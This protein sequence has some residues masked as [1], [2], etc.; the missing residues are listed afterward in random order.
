MVVLPGFH[1]RWEVRPTLR[2][3]S[4]LPDQAAVDSIIASLGS[5]EAALRNHP[6]VATAHV[7]LESSVH[8]EGITATIALAHPSTPGAAVDE[9]TNLLAQA[10]AVAGLTTDIVKEIVAQLAD[11][12]PRSL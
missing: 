11:V 1:R 8:S 9:A 10:C 3:T 4:R 2:L 6:N 12:D 5:V 7:G